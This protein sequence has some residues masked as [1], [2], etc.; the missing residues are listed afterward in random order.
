MLN[1]FN[2]NV[3]IVCFF[4]FGLVPF[5]LKKQNPH[6]SRKRSTGNFQNNQLIEIVDVQRNKFPSI[7][8]GLTAVFIVIHAMINNIAILDVGYELGRRISD[9]CVFYMTYA[10]LSVIIFQVWRTKKSHKRMIQLLHEA[11]EIFSNNKSFSRIKRHDFRWINCT[12]ILLSFLF[13]L[14]EGLTL[15]AVL[16]VGEYYFLYW[17]HVVFPVAVAHVRCMQFYF[18]T[19]ILSTRLELAKNGL[20]FL[21]SK[22]KVCELEG[23]PMT[24]VQQILVRDFC[25][26][27]LVELRKIYDRLYEVH[28]LIN[29]TMG[30][31]MFMAVIQIFGFLCTNSYWSILQHIDKTSSIHP[32]GKFKPS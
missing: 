7:F 30:N 13:F 14:Q 22:K 17:S 28:R 1:F 11:D 19:A 23:W 12:L 27:Q 9:T 24:A 32:I 20:E 5:T 6:F 25:E 18:Y 3:I 4:T 31:S 8:I 29:Y 10:T 26:N 15:F 16:E 2:F 21:V